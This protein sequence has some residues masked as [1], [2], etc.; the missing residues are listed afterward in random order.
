MAMSL[1]LAGLRISGT[2]IEDPA[3]TAQ[4]YPNFWTDL[5]RL[6]HNSTGQVSSAS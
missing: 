5:D 2:E 1:A 4:T 3:C 6:V